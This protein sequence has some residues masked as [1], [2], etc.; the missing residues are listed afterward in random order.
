MTTLTLHRHAGFADRFRALAQM[1]LAPRRLVGVAG[2][3][4]SRLLGSG[5][6]NGFARRP[7]WGVYAMLTVWEE[8]AAAEAFFAHHPWWQRSLATQ[9]E[10]A[11]FFLEATLSHGA[12]G[13]AN[14]FPARPADYDP[15]APVAVLT[16]AT[17]RPRRL[18]EFWR[19]VPRTAASAYDQ[20]ARR[21]SI[22]VGEYPL[23]MQA[24]FSLWT[25]GRAMQDFA[26]A[27]PHHA[28]VVRRTRQRDWYAE[29]LFA[30][31]R[32]V[33]ATGSWEKRPVAELL[34]R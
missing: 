25:S 34:E 7:N 16:R 9:C 12:W 22:G 29:E 30:R 11:T 14:P 32:V 23:F 15:A 33:E 28:E 19:Y 20:P 26:Y 31:F 18:P 3:R 13:G 8:R 5:G 4:F 21:L 1:G 27:S 17:I 10:T 2:M 6:G 24:T